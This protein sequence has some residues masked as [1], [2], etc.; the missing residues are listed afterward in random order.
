[1]TTP[2]PD[3]REGERLR[4]RLATLEAERRELLLLVELAQQLVG[5]LHPSDIAHAVVRRLG[6]AFGLDR[7]SVFLAERDGVTVRL[8]ASHEDPGIRNYVVDLNRYPELRR[9]LQTGETVLISDATADP[10]L[11]HVREAL[12]QRNVRTIAA[13]PIA[14]RGAPIGV[15][16]LRTFQDASALTEREIRLCQ[17]VAD[18][19]A[20]ALRAAH[21]FERVLARRGDDPGARLA[22]RRRE[23]L[24]AFQR[25]LLDRLAER[26]G[27]WTEGDLAPQSAQELDRLVEVALTVISQEASGR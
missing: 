17:A 21:R 6:E 5:A 12:L 18:L 24:L 4:Q 19:T 14:W 7:C 13:V 10:A 23:A 3:A 16:F 11:V 25:R 1:M 20:R 9:V 26:E 27:A 2:T 15:L 8:V 22:E